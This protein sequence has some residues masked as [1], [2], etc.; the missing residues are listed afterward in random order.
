MQPV[1]VGEGHMGKDDGVRPGAA[2]GLRAFGFAGPRRGGRG[3]AVLLAGQVDDRKHPGGLGRPLGQHRAQ[4]A[5]RRE[6][7][8]DLVGQGQRHDHVGKIHPA[9]AGQRRA[10]QQHGQ[11]HPH[12]AEQAVQAAAAGQQ[13]GAPVHRPGQGGQGGVQ[14]ALQHR[15]QAVAAHLLPAADALVHQLGHGGL[16]GGDL[17][18][19]RLQ[20]AGKAAH[21][22]IVAQGAAGAQ[23]RHHPVHRQ[24]PGKG[25]SPRQDRRPDP[26]GQVE[27]HQLHRFAQ[28]GGKAGQQ[29]AGRQRRGGVLPGVKQAV[30]HPAAQGVLGALFQPGKAQAGKAGQ[31]RKGRDQ[32]QVEGQVAGFAAGL[33][34]GQQQHAP[35]Q[36]PHRRKDQEQRQRIDAGTQGVQRGV[37]PGP[38]Q[39]GIQRPGVGGLVSFGHGVHLLPRPGRP[40]PPAYGPPRTGTPG[41]PPRPDRGCG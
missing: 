36:H 16:P 6:H 12:P 5:Q 13:R 23:R 2:G 33:A 18:A 38:A 1:G 19:Q 7:L 27:P 17:A 40:G 20:P 35:Q 26:P 22:R 24:Q 37:A 4:V 11:V 32:P 25:Q 41:R 10:A 31:H 9:G 28:V 34:L 29:V 14:P 3:P 8:A 30:Q 21:H 39:P 15:A